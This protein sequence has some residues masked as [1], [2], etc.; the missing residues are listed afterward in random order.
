MD[1]DLIIGKEI[2]VFFIFLGSIIT[3]D[4]DCNHEIK[5]YLLLGRKA[6]TNLG[7]ILKSCHIKK[8]HYFA[9]KSPPGQGYGFSSSHVWMWELDHKE[10]WALKNWCFW[11]VVLEKTLESP[12]DY[13]EIQP[14]HSEEDQ[15]PSPWPGS[16]QC[17]KR[18]MARTA[19]QADPS[20]SQQENSVLQLRGNWILQPE[21][22]LEEDP[23]LSKTAALGDTAVSWI[24]AWWD[25]SRGTSHHALMTQAVPRKIIHCVV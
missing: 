17:C 8:R 16:K 12:L 21:V 19:C 14:V 2:N 15:R 22:S 20:K 10:S 23:S 18:P 3:A 1:I 4:C 9:N 11:N 6:M 24:S 5:R 25:L 13:Q 7:S